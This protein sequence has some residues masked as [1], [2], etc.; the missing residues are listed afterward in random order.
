MFAEK[1]LVTFSVETE[2][3]VSERHSN[4]KRSP[5]SYELW[6]FQWGSHMTYAVRASKNHQK[7][8]PGQQVCNVSSSLL[9]IS[10]TITSTCTLT[11]R[12]HTEEKE[13][14]V[15]VW[16]FLHGFADH[17]PRLWNILRTYNRKK[18]TVTLICNT[19]FRTQSILCSLP[20]IRFQVTFDKV[21]YLKA[22]FPFRPI[23]QWQWWSKD[24]FT[25]EEIEL[26][27]PLIA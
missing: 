17:R 4:K 2:N 24:S 8:G 12:R 26:N 6:V 25:E 27:Q 18:Y 1:P 19:T 14:C 22:A 9:L 20:Q 13:G 23:L 5:Y 7:W 21:I 3:W 11:E 15:H 10:Q 16:C